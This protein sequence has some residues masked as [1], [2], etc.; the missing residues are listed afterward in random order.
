[1]IN[2]KECL[3]L[4]H[5]CLCFRQGNAHSSVCGVFYKDIIVTIVLLVVVQVQVYL[6][7]FFY[8]FHQHLLLGVH[9]NFHCFVV[10]FIITI[11]SSCRSSRKRG[12]RYSCSLFNGKAFCTTHRLLLLYFVLF[13]FFHVRLTTTVR[14]HGINK[15][16]Q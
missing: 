9:F 13:F 15:V 8:I 11:G 12:N 14:Q 10:F 7:L 16:I 2:I 3:H 4:D 6:F 5:T 1:M